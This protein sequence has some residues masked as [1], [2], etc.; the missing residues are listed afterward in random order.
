MAIARLFFTLYMVGIGALYV[1]TLHP[2]NS[3]GQR[4]AHMLF[5]TLAAFIIGLLMPMPDAVWI[6]LG[7][8]SFPIALTCGYLAS[9]VISKLRIK[10][11]DKEHGRTIETGRKE[12]GRVGGP[13]GLGDS[14]SEAGDYPGVR[15]DGR[16]GISPSHADGTDTP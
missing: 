2:Y 7:Y 6:A 5:T 9:K 4:W 3:N 12:G 15:L 13:N 11:W 10:H 16:A 14:A 1:A 8:S